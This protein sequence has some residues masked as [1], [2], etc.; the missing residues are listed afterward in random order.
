MYIKFRKEFQHTV[1]QI[2]FACEKF[3]KGSQEPRHQEYFSPQTYL[4][5]W[6]AEMVKKKTLMQY[7]QLI[8]KNMPK[9]RNRTA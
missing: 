5:L 8:F 3:S 4:G 1:N 7:E 2:L 9:K 6:V